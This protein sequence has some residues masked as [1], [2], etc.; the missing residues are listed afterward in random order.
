MFQKNGKKKKT[1]DILVSV[2]N[3]GAPVG[4]IVTEVSITPKFDDR[5]EYKTKICILTRWLN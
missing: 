2:N 1:I 4:Y 3:Q 5:P